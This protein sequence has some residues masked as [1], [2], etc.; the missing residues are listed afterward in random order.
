MAAGFGSHKAVANEAPLLAFYYTFPYALFAV[1][2]LSE[3]FLA[4]TFLLAHEGAVT[5]ATCVVG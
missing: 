3:S 1:C 5:A 4:M 2:L